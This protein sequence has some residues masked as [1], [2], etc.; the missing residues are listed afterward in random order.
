M[1]DDLF[2]VDTNILVYAFDSDETKKRDACKRLIEMS[3]NGTEEYAISIQNLSEFY[4][5]VT[6]KI[7][8]P[9]SSIIARQIIQDIIDFSNWQVLDFNSG[10]LISAMK[11]NSK[12]N[13]HYWDALICATMLENGINC[14]YTENVKDFDKIPGLTVVNP[15]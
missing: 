13:I 12:Y 4:V 14:I 2:L 3:W 15:I 11:L 9:I 6:K 10:T 1:S 5:I 8:Y 7:Q